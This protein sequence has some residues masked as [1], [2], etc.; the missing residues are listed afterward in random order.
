MSWRFL[1]GA[2]HRLT[3]LGQRFAARRVRGMCGKPY[4][5]APHLQ[6]Q[7]HVHMSLQT[8]RQLGAQR[9]LHICLKRTRGRET[10]DETASARR[11]KSKSISRAAIKYDMQ[12][13]G[14]IKIALASVINRLDIL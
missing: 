8:D 11:R 6:E 2:Q 1:V 3:C 9:R 14:S 5:A 12:A 10:F 4:V 13:C 7:H